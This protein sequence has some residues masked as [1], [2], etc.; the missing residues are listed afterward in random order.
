MVISAEFRMYRDDDHQ[1][2][3]LRFIKSRIKTFHWWQLDVG[4]FMMVTDGG[5]F[6]GHQSCH[7]H[8]LYKTFVTNID[9]SNARIL[10]IF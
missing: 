3:T 4:A 6:F 5:N 10:L 7:H 9:I 1:E 8:K 2:D